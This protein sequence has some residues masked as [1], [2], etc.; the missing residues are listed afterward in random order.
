MIS[1][2]LMYNLKDFKSAGDNLQ[3]A[4]FGVSFI[5]NEEIQ[6]LKRLEPSTILEVSKVFQDTLSLPTDLRNLLACEADTDLQKFCSSYV[7]DLTNSIK[8]FILNSRRQQNPL[9]GI[10]KIINYLHEVNQEVLSESRE[11]WRHAQLYPLV[12][13]Y[14]RISHGISELCND[15]V[16]LVKDVSNC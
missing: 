3:V 2:L 4:K 1:E 15:F 8:Q 10:H 6:R 12:Y 14:Y 7:D 16:R 5:R 9:N 13:D 11:E